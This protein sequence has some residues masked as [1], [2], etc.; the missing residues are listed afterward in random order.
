MIRACLSAA[1][2]VPVSLGHAQTLG[3]QSLG[4]RAERTPIRIVAPVSMSDGTTAAGLGGLLTVSLTQHSGGCAWIDYNGDYLPDLFVTNGSGFAHYL[5]RNEGDGTFTDVSSLIPK[6]VLGLEEAA[7]VFADADNDGDSDLFIAV[8]NPA[9]LGTTA[10][11]PNLFYRNDG[12]SFTQGALPAGLVSGVRTITAGFADFD[13]DGLVDLHCG[14]WARAVWPLA[15][16]DRLFHNGG[17]LSFTDVTATAG[18]DGLERNNLTTL[19]FDVDLDLW[20]DLYVGNVGEF[21]SGYVEPENHDVLYTNDAN[22]TS[23]SAATTSGIGDDATAAMGMDVGDI[24][25]DGDWDLYITDNPV[26]GAAPF[27]NVLY[28]GNGTTLED[29]SCDVAGVCLVKNSWACSFADWNRDGWVDLFV[30]T[31]KSSDPDALFV[32]QGDGTFVDQPQAA[33]AG[34]RVLGGSHADFDGDGDVD[35]FLW[36]SSQAPRLIVNDGVDGNRHLSVKLFGTTSNR[37]AIG[38]TVRVTANGETQMRRVSGGDSAH[39]QQ[40]LILHFGLESALFCDVEVTWPSGLVQSFLSVGTDELIFVDETT[41]LMTESLASGVAR[42]DARDGALEIEVRSSFG[43]RS[44]FQAEGLGA[45]RFDASRGSYVGRFR[46][47]ERLADVTLRSKRGQ[48]FLLSV[49]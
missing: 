48:R 4:T 36:L 14:T 29:N 38:A 31:T 34:N 17:G 22:G 5:F 10:G 7:A 15:F 30:G 2:L 42:Y 46:P 37:D 21:S 8:D 11:G 33:L 16:G 12:G 23:F 49:R 40:E 25:N 41:G 44:G 45:L 39:S 3:G 20:P 6:P 43:G 18:T 1:C 32:N 19:W 9:S 24:D 35:L 28:K 27:G 13:R 47:H 26:E